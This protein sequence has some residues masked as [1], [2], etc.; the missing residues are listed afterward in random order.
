[1]IPIDEGMAPLRA[2]KHAISRSVGHDPYRYSAYVRTSA[3]L[4]VPLV[5]TIRS[6]PK[7]TKSTIRSKEVGQK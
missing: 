6:Q 4:Y 5:A 7:R 3:K 2:V 1:M